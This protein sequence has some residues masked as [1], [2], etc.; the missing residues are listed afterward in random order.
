MS[1]NSLLRISPLRNQVPQFD[2]IREE[3]FKPAVIEA[4][5][6]ARENIDQIIHHSEPPTFENTIVALETAPGN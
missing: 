3:D 5:T 2:Q 1:N 6:Q 4:I